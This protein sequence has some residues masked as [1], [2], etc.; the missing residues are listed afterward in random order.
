[1]KKIV[2]YFF[3]AFSF[4]IFC[5]QRHFSFSTVKKE[6]INSSSAV[7]CQDAK[8]VL[9]CG[10]NCFNDNFCVGFGFN[11]NSQH[12]FGLHDF[13]WD[14]YSYQPVQ[15]TSDK[16]VWYRSGCRPNWVEFKGHCYFYGKLKKVSWFE[17]K[18]ECQ[19][20]FSHL[21]EIEDKAESDWLASTFLNPDGNYSNC[22]SNTSNGCSAWTGLNDLNIEGQYVWD[23]SNTPMAFYTWYTFKPEFGDIRDCVAIQKNGQWNDKKCMALLA[24]ICEKEI[25]NL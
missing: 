2:V 6:D 16:I 20:R 9:Y 4:R 3:L 24:F 7:F 10:V 18:A 8:T 25:S 14:G 17:A 13:E 22:P 11:T 15:S 23:H 5:E 21:V 1:M 19:N 12:C